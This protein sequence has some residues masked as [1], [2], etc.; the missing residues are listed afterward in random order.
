[1]RIGEILRY[2]RPYSHVDAVR[3]GLG[4]FFHATFTNGQKLALLESGIN[5]IRNPRD[6]AS[7]V[8]DARVPNN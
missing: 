6:R 7:A 3:D 2:A 1:M 8:L 4:N 5:A